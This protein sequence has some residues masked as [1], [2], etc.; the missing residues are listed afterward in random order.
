IEPKRLERL[1]R[2]MAHSIC[3]SAFM[4]RRS[5]ATGRRRRSQSRPSSSPYE[6]TARRH[7]RS[8]PTKNGLGAAV[9][10]RVRVVGDAGDTHSDPQSG[11]SR[12]KVCPSDVWSEGN[13]AVVYS[14]DE[15]AARLHKSRR[16]LQDW[17]RDHP[18]DGR[19]EPFYSPLGRTKTFDDHDLERIRAS[20]R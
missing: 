14:M 6:S 19:G 8:P 18:V 15:A 13:A 4:T 16:W 20:A 11:S 2:F 5:A 17:L 12:G 9:S 1:R 10:S 3:W 7:W